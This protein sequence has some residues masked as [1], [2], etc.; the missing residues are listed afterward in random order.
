MPSVRVA[1]TTGAEIA[2]VWFLRTAALAESPVE[3][4]RFLNGQFN[5]PLPLAMAQANQV[6]NHPV[7]FVLI[8]SWSLDAHR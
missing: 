4:R 2:L 1:T 3:S 8:L 7:E 6:A 5:D